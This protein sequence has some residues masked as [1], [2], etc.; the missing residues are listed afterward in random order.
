MSKKKA[1]FFKGASGGG[2]S[3]AY[4]AVI[5]EAVSLYG[6]GSLPTAL[7]QEAQNQIVINLQTSGVWD[8]LDLF[9]YFKDTGTPDFKFINWITPTGTKAVEGGGGT[10]LTYNSLG[11]KGNGLNRHILLGVTWVNMSL[12]S[13]SWT[14]DVVEED[15]GKAFLSV[16]SIVQLINADT[17][18]YLNNSGTGSRDIKDF[19]GAHVFGVD[20]NG[21]TFDGWVDGVISPDTSTE[22][23]TIVPTT[24][25]V[26]LLRLNITESSHRIGYVAAGSFY[27]QT[28]FFNSL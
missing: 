28:D 9:Y 2:F 17:L 1:M 13:T 20:M 19:T 4:Q 5:D 3:D 6:T 21:T 25:D 16:A 23:P 11:V 27:N 15:A 18:Q 14:C 10:P 22:S 8:S 24:E 12:N 26:Q 7:E